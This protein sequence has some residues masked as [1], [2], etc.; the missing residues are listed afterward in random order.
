MS[1]N[2]IR[3]QNQPNQPNLSHQRRDE[4][5]AKGK[6]EETKEIEESKRERYCRKKDR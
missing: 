4:W 1:H 2:Q 5:K 3:N 6:K